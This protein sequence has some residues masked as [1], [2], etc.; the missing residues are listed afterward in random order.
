MGDAK[1]DYCIGS[2]NAGLKRAVAS[3]LKEAGFYAA[4]EG[5]NT[6]EF[7]RILRLKQPWLA[8]IDTSIPPGNI[9]QLASI[10]EED[11][12]SATLFIST[13][14][15]NLNGFMLLKW[16]VDTRVLSAVA[17]TLCLE[18]ARKKELNKKILGLE[19][20]LSNRKEIE[21]A[22]GILMCKLAFDEES[23]YRYLQQ[24]SMENRLSMIETA[25]MIIANSDF[26]VS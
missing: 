3:M 18:F 10:I 15:I 8:I 24:K 4:G 2:A 1:Y 23:A 12:L 25:R 20:K 7:L 13:V 22:K 21:K 11:N 26:A 14:N 19:N 17:E 6:P 5:K 16:P 9:R